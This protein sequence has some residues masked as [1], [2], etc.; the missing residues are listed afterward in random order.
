MSSS[1]RSASGTISDTCLYNITDGFV[2]LA[3]VTGPIYSYYVDM[4][5]KTIVPCQDDPPLLNLTDFRDGYNPCFSYT[6][7]T[8]FYL[9]LDQTFCGKSMPSIEV[10]LNSSSPNTSN[11]SVKLLV[12]LLF[13]IWMLMSG[14]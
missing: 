11:F 1:S 14:L 9:G 8:S 2:Y 13:T 3:L 12:F 7:N 6:T 10:N 5:N 4:S